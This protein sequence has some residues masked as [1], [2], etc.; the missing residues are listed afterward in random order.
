MTWQPVLVIQTSTDWLLTESVSGTLFRIS[1][2]VSGTNPQ[3]LRSVIAQAFDEGANNT[4]FDFRRLSFKPE[5]EAIIFIQPNG[6]LNRK[7]AIKRLDNLADDWTITIEVLDGMPESISLPI[8]ISEVTGLQEELDAKELAGAG[9]A[10]AASVIANHETAANPHSQYA[11]DSQINDLQTAINTKINSDDSRLLIQ[12]SLTL[13]GWEIE[14][15]GII[16]QWGTARLTTTNNI[17]FGSPLIT[18][19]LVFPNQVL[20]IVPNLLGSDTDG[21]IF[22]QI[23][24]TQISNNSCIF[25]ARNNINVSGTYIDIYYQVFGY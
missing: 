22:G 8:T 3:S 25:L 4:Y 17:D 19:P 1:H 10:A 16:K 24:P 18:F 5:A 23:I 15:G 9:A 20:N 21:R 2:N 11:T 14:A 6:L 7:L 12:Q 13:P